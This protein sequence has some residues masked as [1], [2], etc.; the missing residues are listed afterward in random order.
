MSK[1]SCTFAP[2]KVSTA[3]RHSLTLNR[4]TSAKRRA[5]TYLNNK[6]Y[7]YFA[8]KKKVRKTN[9]LAELE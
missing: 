9:F 3:S 7:Y 4:R 2:A 8:F 5:K 6:H 1:N